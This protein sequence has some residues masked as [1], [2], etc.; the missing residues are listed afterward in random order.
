MIPKEHA[1]QEKPFHVG[2][3]L[4]QS[5]LFRAHLG[6]N[7]TL[8]E[9]YCLRQLSIEITNFK[10]PNPANMRKIFAMLLLLIAFQSFS[11]TRALDSLKKL[12][13]DDKAEDSL[14]VSRL[15]EYSNLLYNAA[16]SS[17]QL[18]CNPSIYIARSGIQ[19]ANK[20]NRPDLASNCYLLIGMI[21]L[22]E[23]KQ[24]SAIAVLY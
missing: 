21:Y 4:S 12:I 14:K 3:L 1:D 7:C 20:I 18:D 13:D 5:K 16:V 24:D 17:P 10:Y 6:N 19:L 11:Q 23:D 9:R 15:Y 2:G 8:D 22:M